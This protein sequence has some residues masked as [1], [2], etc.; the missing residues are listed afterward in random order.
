MGLAVDTFAARFPGLTLNGR[1][2]TVGS[3][4]SWNTYLD[5]ADPTTLLSRSVGPI[6][7]VNPLS[8]DDDRREVAGVRVSGGALFVA[9]DVAESL[10]TTG[11]Q[12]ESVRR[13]NLHASDIP[14]FQETVRADALRRIT[15]HEVQRSFRGVAPTVSDRVRTAV[16]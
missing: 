7:C 15:A 8:F 1:P 3:V 12:S 4:L 10:D 11:R 14:L 2:G 13:G 16:V 5:G 9:P 6:A